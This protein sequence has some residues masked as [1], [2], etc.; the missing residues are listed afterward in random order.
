MLLRFLRAT[1]PSVYQRSLSL[2]SFPPAVSLKSLAFHS[3]PSLKTVRYF[4]RLKQV[5]SAPKSFRTF[6]SSTFQTE[7]QIDGGVYQGLTIL[8]AALLW[9]YAAPESVKTSLLVS[10][11]GFF[12]SIGLCE[13]TIT[14]KMLLEDYF[15]RNIEAAKNVVL[16]SPAFYG[17]WHFVHGCSLKVSFM[18]S[19]SGSI[20]IM[21]F[22]ILFYGGFAVISPFV[23]SY[24]MQSHDQDYATASGN[25][26]VAM[27]FSGFALLE[28]VV[29]LRGCGVG[30]AQM[31]IPMTFFIFLPALI[32]RLCAGVLTQQQ[33]A[34]PNS[35]F[36]SVIPKSWSSENASA[37]QKIAANIFETLKVDTAFF[38]TILGTSIGQ[39]VLNACTF[40]MLTKGKASNG[41]DVLKYLGG[42]V[43]GTPLGGLMQM[44][45]TVFLRVTFCATWNWFS[46][47]K[48][49]TYPSITS[50]LVKLEK[51][52]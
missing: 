31:N 17:V 52:N 27:M 14:N 48:S 33:K 12:R 2:H 25:S 36:Q 23:T 6:S 21:P 18:R 49:L 46:S 24:F 20:R 39:H 16:A 43:D 15:Q 11:T 40:I 50:T 34:G 26:G 5:S 29:E 30:F 10:T 13:K 37:P 3:F 9:S 44:M 19:I 51:G 4:S 47:Q 7:A 42:G 1:A 32:L 38:T 35:E 22:M 8:G 41:K 28:S 45:R